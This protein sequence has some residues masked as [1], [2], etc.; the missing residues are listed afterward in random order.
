MIHNKIL[1]FLIIVSIL[2][3]VKNGYSQNDSTVSSPIICNSL[4]MFSNKEQSEE[5][6]RDSSFDFSLSLWRKFYKEFVKA[7]SGKP[8][9]EYLRAHRNKDVLFQFSHLQLIDTSLCRYSS[10]LHI[11]STKQVDVFEMVNALII[12][13]ENYFG[14]YFENSK[15]DWFVFICTKN[16]VHIRS[17][18]EVI[19][20]LV[21]P[22]HR[23]GKYVFYKMTDLHIQALQLPFI[24]NNK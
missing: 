17:S 5:I 3:S 15:N 10:S 24:L 13:R 23:K 9:D 14:F 18:I 4:K 20:A 21:A 12:F 8:N 22:S 19:N 16:S 1:I 2:V 11:V 7:I 6:M